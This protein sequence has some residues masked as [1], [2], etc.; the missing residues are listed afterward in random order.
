MREH[1]QHEVEGAVEVGQS[2][3]LV[4][5][6]HESQNGQQVGGV[7]GH[8]SHDPRAPDLENDFGA[9]VKHGLMHLGHR[10]R[11]HRTSVPRPQV[12]PNAGPFE[13]VGD[14]RGRRRRHRVTTTGKRVGD[15]GRCQTA[16]RRNQLAELHVGRPAP[17]S[18]L[19]EDGHDRLGVAAPQHRHEVWR[20]DAGQ[21]GQ[22]HDRAGIEGRRPDDLVSSLGG[23]AQQLRQAGQQPVA[24]LDQAR[25]TGRPLAAFESTAHDAVERM[26]STTTAANSSPLSSWRK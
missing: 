22:P 15:P 18:E 6:L 26:K 13:Y 12:G 8:H 3:P 14:G 16:G 1:P 20:G 24:L 2:N 17:Q 25:S 19:G 9:V 4:S 10:G 21:P 11:C 7:S 5:R 23:L